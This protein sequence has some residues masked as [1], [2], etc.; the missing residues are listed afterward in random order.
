MEY[1]IDYINEKIA[2]WEQKKKYYL[3]KMEEE[4]ICENTDKLLKKIFSVNGANSFI[5]SLY[6]NS[7]TVPIIDN[8]LDSG[9]EF[10]VFKD[11]F[12]LDN[13]M[14]S[15]IITICNKSIRILKSALTITDMKKMT[16]WYNTSKGLDWYYDKKSREY[17]LVSCL[18]ALTPIGNQRA[19]HFEYPCQFNAQ[20]SNNRTGYGNEFCGED[21]VFE[22]TKYG[23]TTTF[24]IIGVLIRPYDDYAKGISLIP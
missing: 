23:E 15:P 7:K 19:L 16:C 8:Y 4:E 21:L 10:L 2:F 9:K 18:F 20:G 1:S 13:Y 6:E 17:P 22:G 11:F 3:E 5:V 24:Y 12:K 14:L